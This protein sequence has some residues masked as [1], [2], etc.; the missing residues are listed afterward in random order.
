MVLNYQI[1]GN[2]PPLLLVHGWGV[3]FTI[4]R[5]LI[6]LLSPHY[7]LII[8][9]LPGIGRSPMPTPGPYYE[10]CATALETLRQDLDIP[11]WHILGYSMGGWVVCDYARRWPERI[12]RLVFLC[13]AR[14]IPV[15][16]WL[17][18][19]VK[20]IDK[21]YPLF[22]DW[23]LSRWRLYVLITLLGFNGKPGPLA[24]VWTDE[25]GSQP[26]SIV[27][28]TIRD[29]PSEGR[30]PFNL[31]DL[32]TRF[33]WGRTD[34]LGVV[35]FRPGPQDM[36]IPGGHDLPMSGADRVAPLIREFLP[37]NSRPPFRNS[38]N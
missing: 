26:I 27:K 28:Q 38:T 22:G 8:P 20:S 5:E 24:R 30:A 10:V 32:P 12:D 35:G 25:I 34:G 37:L 36:I 1:C 11:L 9:E 23:M 4:W 15:A 29:L 6:P 31:P 2:G 19:I 3:S 7:K 13:I 16:A 17:L 21:A 14:P 18:S 33:I